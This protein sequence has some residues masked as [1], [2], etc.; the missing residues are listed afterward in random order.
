MISKDIT[1]KTKVGDETREATMVY[2]VGEDVHE[3]IEMFGEKSVH[4]GFTDDLIIAL[5]G[6][7]RA[8]LTQGMGQEEIVNF[9]AGWKPGV[10][11]TRSVDPVAELIRRYK[12]G[13]MSDEDKAK[14]VAELGLG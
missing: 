2:N 11:L 14:L 12:A 7:M 3:D 1:A 13:E 4:D 9:L 8:C 10:T 5:Q 6:K